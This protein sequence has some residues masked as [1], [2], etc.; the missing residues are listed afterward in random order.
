MDKQKIK[1]HSYT[2]KPTAYATS[3]TGHPGARKIM[4]VK[5]GTW[6]LG[7]MLRVGVAFNGTTP[8]ISIGDG[9]SAVGYMTT[10]QAD[11]ENTGLKAGYGTFFS[12]ANGKLYTTDDTID[13]A[14]TYTAVTSAGECTA[15]I[16]YA[17]VE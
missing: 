7:V 2:F 9:A 13:L 17:E 4:G 6:V 5:R 14:Y 11:I 16:V 10:A 1:I 15:I 8:T 3:E 12:G